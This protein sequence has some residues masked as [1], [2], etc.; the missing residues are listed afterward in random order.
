MFLGPVEKENM[1]VS[2]EMRLDGISHKF[3]Q[4][5]K[6]TRYDQVIVWV[7]H[8]IS[9]YR[10]VMGYLLGNIVASR[11]VG[12]IPVTPKIFSQNWIVRFLDAL[13]I[14]SVC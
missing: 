4:R 11:S 9:G 1:A 14:R 13:C 10:R 8:K 5:L 3:R 6:I 2:L 12:A 7:C